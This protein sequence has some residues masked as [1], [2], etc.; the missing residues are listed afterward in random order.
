[1]TER[2]TGRRAVRQ[3]RAS[4]R[5]PARP[6]NRRSLVF[7]QTLFTRAVDPVIP[8]IAADLAVDVKTAALLSTA[9]TFPYALVQPVLGTIGDFFGK[10]RLMNVMPG[11]R[12]AGR[13]SSAPW[14]RASRCWWRCGWSPGIL[15]GG[16][17]P[18][19]DGAGRRSRAGQE[20]PGG[21]RPAACGRPHRQRAGRI[22]RRRDR[23]SVRL[24]RRVRRPRAVRP[25]RGDRGVLRLPRRT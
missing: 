4:F 9:Y 15:A 20:A 23:R 22:A 6:E 8:Q 13:V 12:R 16:V 14:R 18:I 25:G 3:H 17:F 10:T 1:M 2:R 7:A 21:D 24:A 11:D 19:G 5:H